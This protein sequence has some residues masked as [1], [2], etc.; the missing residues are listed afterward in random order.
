LGTY[1]NVDSDYQRLTQAAINLKAAR[2]REI[3]SDN[4]VPIL[5]DGR[6]ASTKVSDISAPLTLDPLY[7]HRIVSVAEVGELVIT[8]T[9]TYQLESETCLSHESHPEQCNLPQAGA[10]VVGLE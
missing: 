10:D 1:G 9:P 4:E 2:T 3:Q 6:V 5:T 7:A 8:S